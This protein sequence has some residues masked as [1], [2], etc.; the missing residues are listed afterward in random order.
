MSQNVAFRQNTELGWSRDVEMW[1]GDFVD[2]L[3][4]CSSSRELITRYTNLVQAW[5]PHLR[6][7]GS[8][9]ASMRDEN[10]P[11][12]VS[13]QYERMTTHPISNLTNLG[14]GFLRQ[15]SRRERTTV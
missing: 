1:S 2:I 14:L 7:A 5:M 10:I 3:R 4:L 12:C 11:P 13:E 9:L 6:E 15:T 8:G